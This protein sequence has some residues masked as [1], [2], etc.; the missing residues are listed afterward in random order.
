MA[1]LSCIDK[2][3]GGCLNEMLGVRGQRGSGS[4]RVVHGGAPCSPGGSLC[5]VHC[6]NLGSVC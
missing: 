5:L 4:C 2:E 6:R 1:K 3:Q